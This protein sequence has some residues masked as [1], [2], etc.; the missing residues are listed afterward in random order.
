MS[1]AMAIHTCR[2]RTSGA[3]VLLLLAHTVSPPPSH[4]EPDALI[5]ILRQPCTGARCHQHNCSS[6]L[7]RH[8]PACVPAPA[9][10]PARPPGTDVD[11]SDVGNL[12]LRGVELGD[13]NPAALAAGLAQGSDFEETD[14]ERQVRVRR[15]VCVHACAWARGAAGAVWARGIG[16]GATWNG[17]PT[18]VPLIGAMSRALER[19]TGMLLLGAVQGVSS[20]RLLACVC[21]GTSVFSTCLGF[22][23]HSCPVLARHD[24]WHR[25]HAHVPSQSS[26]LPARRRSGS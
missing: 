4:P 5:R 9:R 19:D 12:L 22:S 1:T 7:L 3:G 11:S 6:A 8:A 10:A 21:G 25:D 14:D 20:S 18:L 13:V 16:I 2:V 24:I 15:L 26:A 23:F 17:L